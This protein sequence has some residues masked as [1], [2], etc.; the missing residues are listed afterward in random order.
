M[1]EG[2]AQKPEVRAA[3]EEQKAK[4]EALGAVVVDV[5]NFEAYIF[6]TCIDAAKTLVQNKLLSG[7]HETHGPD[8][9]PGVEDHPA[10]AIIANSLFRE[11]RETM[12]KGPGAESKPSI[13]S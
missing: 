5:V 8:Q 13:V 4:M 7:G 1:A 9:G 10:T 12:R 6:D 2:T 3:L 11:V